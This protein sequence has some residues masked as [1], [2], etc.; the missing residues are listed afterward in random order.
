MKYEIPEM[1]PLA[2]QGLLPSIVNIDS[3][4]ATVADPGMSPYVAAKHAVLGFTQGACMDYA[5][6]GIHINSIGP[7]FV[8]TEMTI[9][10]LENPEFKEMVRNFNAQKYIAEPQDIADVALF[11]C[12]RGVKFIN[13]TH[14]A[15]DGGQTAH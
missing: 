7:A 15:A 4:V 8:A 5:E 6:R 12:S 11:L 13:G 10:W 1:L 14:I 3:V 2:D 9:P